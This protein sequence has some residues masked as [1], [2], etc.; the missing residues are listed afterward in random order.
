MLAKDATSKDISEMKKKLL[1]AKMNMQFDR[2]CMAV[3]A[4]VN[5]H[6]KTVNKKEK[7]V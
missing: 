1:D 4:I 2:D 3:I 7:T 5:N 6:R